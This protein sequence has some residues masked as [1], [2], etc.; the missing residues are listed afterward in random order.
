MNEDPVQSNLTTSPLN[1]S[2]T[3]WRT[4]CIVWIQSIIK[5]KWEEDWDTQMCKCHMDR[6]IK[7]ICNHLDSIWNL[8]YAHLS[9]YNSHA[10]YHISISE[11]IKS[12]LFRI[13]QT[14]FRSNLYTSLMFYCTVLY[15][16]KY[17]IVLLFF[18]VDFILY[19]KYT[20][21]NALVLQ[22]LTHVF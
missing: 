11:L 2:L 15:N 5:H 21:M 9:N 8:K 19:W 6:Y 22:S 3:C 1:R 12:K 17:C 13:Y 18:R 10:T 4:S 7:G 20:A 14:E 16:N